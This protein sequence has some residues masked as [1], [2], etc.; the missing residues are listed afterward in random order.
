MRSGG[1]RLGRYIMT[2][3]N[4]YHNDGPLKGRG[5]PSYDVGVD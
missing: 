2:K 1:D 3:V 5:V 4:V